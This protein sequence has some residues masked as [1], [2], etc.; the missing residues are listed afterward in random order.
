MT[1]SNKNIE[2]K[3]IIEY[4]INEYIHFP[5]GKLVK[6]E[7]PDFI[8]KQSPKRSIGIELTKL[9]HPENRFFYRDKRNDIQINELSKEPI[10]YTIK[11]KEEKLP[12][13]QKKKINTFWLIITLEKYNVSKSLNLNNKFENWAFSSKFQKVFLFELVNR[14]V[15]ELNT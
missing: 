15:Y 10:E 7:S 9:H 11:A 1:N 2:E 13:Y 14:K 8:L 4:F 3:L 6:S 12:L 5:K